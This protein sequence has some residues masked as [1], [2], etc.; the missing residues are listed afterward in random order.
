MRQAP[1]QQGPQLRPTPTPR[2]VLG[3][4]TVQKQLPETERGEEG[5]EDL[6]RTGG[7]AEGG[8]GSEVRG[9]QPSPS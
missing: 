6:G 9:T 4:L 5:D 8:E 2:P 7:G 1:P 3:H